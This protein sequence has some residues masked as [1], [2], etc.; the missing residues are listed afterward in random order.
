ML[1][2]TKVSRMA[3]TH[4]LFLLP[5]PIFAHFKGDRERIS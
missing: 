5:P 1:D 2:E 3:K 4:I